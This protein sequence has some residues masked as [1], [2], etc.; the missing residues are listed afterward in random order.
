VHYS[1]EARGYAG[2]VLFSLVALIFLQREL[3]RP[4]RLNRHA[5]GAAIGLGLLS[6]LMMAASAAT[7]AAW[8]AWVIWHRAGN[9]RDAEA[10][11]RKIFRPALAWTA[12]IVA[13]ILFGALRHGFTFGGND[14][15]ESGQLVEG[16]GG[17]LRLL[18]G[19]PEQV[20]AWACLAGV[21]MAVVSAAYLWR[22]REDFRGSLYVG[23][24]IGLPAALFLAHLPNLQFGRYF[25]FSGAIFLLFVGEVLCL[26]WRKGGAL[27]T[28][29]VVALLAIVAGNAVSLR[30][31]FDSGRG[32]YLDAVT[33][34]APTGSFIYGTDSNFRIPTLVDFYSRRLHVSAHH[35]RPP[36]WCRESPDWMVIENLEIQRSRTELTVGAP[37]C[38]LTYRLRNIFPAWG[39]SGSPWAVYRRLP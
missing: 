32:H 28:A 15:F 3:E 34:M 20:P 10:V 33:Q 22:D 7:L 17:I 36:E 11:T 37:D 39:L 14:R 29:A 25:L 27:R 6:H 5:L 18:L 2:L 35:V 16:Y 9:F 19:L 38:A 24:V 23:S 8:T 1:S 12:V 26:G 31:F 4:N 30:Q 13:A 21:A